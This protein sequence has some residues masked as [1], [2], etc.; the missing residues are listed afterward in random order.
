MGKL[1][2]KEVR[3]VARITWLGSRISTMPGSPMAGP[4]LGP[5][6]VLGSR[7]LGARWQEAQVLGS[8]LIDSLEPA[9]ICPGFVDGV[10]R[11]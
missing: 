5:R 9:Q 1:R 3:T 7:V 2:L 11:S 8:V 4:D 10:G 6:G